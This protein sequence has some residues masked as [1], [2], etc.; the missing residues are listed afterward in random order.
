MPPVM[1][2]ALVFT[3]ANSK[4]SLATPRVGGERSV[5]RGVP[6]SGTGVAN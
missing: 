2:D 4:P 1:A 3:K 5:N 6:R